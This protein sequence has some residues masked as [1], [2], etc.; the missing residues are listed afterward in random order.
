MGRPFG[1]I[2]SVGICCRKFCGEE[3]RD[4]CENEDD[5]CYYCFRK[6]RYCSC[7]GAK[8][9][10]V[11]KNSEKIEKFHPRSNSRDNGNNKKNNEENKEILNAIT[12]EDQGWVRPEDIQFGIKL[13]SG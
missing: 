12:N 3:G 1:P 8:K 10:N 6:H 7:K 5:N 9:T 4:G 11:I 2:L 13:G